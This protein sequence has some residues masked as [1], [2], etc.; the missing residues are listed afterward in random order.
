MLIVIEG[1]SAAGK[2]TRAT[3]YA[4]AVVPELACPAPVGDDAAVGEYW[5]ARHTERWL[6][7]LALE[8]IHGTACFDTDPL[9]IHYAWCLWQTG[10]GTRATWLAT[11]QATRARLLRREIG[12]A[13]VIVLQR[14][15]TRRRRGNFAIN[16]QLQAPLRRWYA[17]LESLALGRVVFE[18]HLQPHVA[19]GVPREDRYSVDLLDALVERT[20]K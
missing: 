5:S 2:T 13:D 3:H 4:P 8:Q 10:H 12:F 14:Q 1:I 15:G 17:L 16:V 11:V 7:G 20:S 18:G 19:G 6:A 9:K